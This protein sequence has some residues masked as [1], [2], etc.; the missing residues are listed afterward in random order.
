MTDPRRLA[1]PTPPRRRLSLTSLIDVIFLLL[2]FFMLA[3][4]FAREVEFDLALAG[5]GAEAPDRRPI[6]LQLGPEALTLN[7]ESLA[8]DDLAATLT[9]AEAEAPVLVALAEGVQAQRLVDVLAVLR[10]T[11]H[12]ARVLR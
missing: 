1:A 8:L 7:G 12:P 11:T 5:T 4:T 9:T 10:T 6:F 3:S 2:M